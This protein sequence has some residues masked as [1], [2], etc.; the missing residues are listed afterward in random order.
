MVRPVSPPTRLALTLITAAGVVAGCSSAPEQQLLQ[1]YFS[2]ARLRDQTTLANIAT[3]GFNPNDRGTVQRFDLTSV[4][5]EQTRTLEIRKLK[6][7]FD[8]ARKADE[9]FTKKKQAYQDANADAIARVVR[10]DREN[11]KLGGKDGQ[12]QIE[13]AKWREETAQHAKRVTDARTALAN[14]RGMAEI[15]VFDAR[16][17][18]DVSEYDGQLMIK[19]VVIAAQVRSPAG[20]VAT[21]NLTIT[22][23]RAQLHNGRQIEGRWIITDIK[24]SS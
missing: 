5:A 14:E 19:D 16:N 3:V 23:Q 13:W 22:L 10:A 7:A 15:S 4:G 21:K 6:Q 8:E 2:A 17:P 1:K 11:R 20:E 18:V 12:I 24:E 9:E